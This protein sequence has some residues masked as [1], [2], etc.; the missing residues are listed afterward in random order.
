M[1]GSSR[2]GYCPLFR[3]FQTA[4][5]SHFDTT[6]RSP[7]IDWQ[8]AVT[9]Y[10]RWLPHPSRLSHPRVPGRALP[11]WTALPCFVSGNLGGRMSGLAGSHRSPL[12]SARRTTVDKSPALDYQQGLARIP[13]RGVPRL[14][15]RQAVQGD[16]D[17]HC[18][19][20][21]VAHC[22]VPRRPR[23]GFGCGQQ[24]GWAAGRP[25]G[26]ARRGSARALG[27]ARGPWEV[28]QELK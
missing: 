6:G 10:C 7:R 25:L 4:C 21:A 13:H 16:S 14:A 24:P 15:G 26:T 11:M 27:Q 9:D 3:F 5:V 19:C 1:T 22:G 20:E 17:E 12:H 23:R 28:W 18:F 2:L 8:E